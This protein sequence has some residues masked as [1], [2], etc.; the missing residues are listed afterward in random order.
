MLKARGHM[1]TKS[2]RS[3]PGPKPYGLAEGG[4]AANHERQVRGEI[5]RLRAAGWGLGRIAKKLNA[6]G[7]RACRRCLWH[8]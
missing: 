7:E 5:V 2:R 8:P 3:Q 6:N 1:G 4:A